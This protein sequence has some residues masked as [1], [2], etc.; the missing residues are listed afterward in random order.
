MF[1]PV[2]VSSAA[3]YTCTYCPLQ[4][5]FHYRPFIGTYNNRTIRTIVI[6][7][8]R[9]TH[10]DLGPGGGGE[11]T[12]GTLEGAGIHVRPLVVLHI[13]ASVERLHAY[14]AG[15][16]LGAETGRTHCRGRSWSF[17]AQLRYTTN[18]NKQHRQRNTQCR[19]IFTCQQSLSYL[20]LLQNSIRQCWSKI[21]LVTFQALWPRYFYSLR[22]TALIITAKTDV[23]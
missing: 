7:T 6:V 12:V 23:L 5:T 1:N 17:T 3:K 18:A 4:E 15:E 8:H 20:H 10:L 22:R 19:Q 11:V 16:P 2:Q 14:A 21:V 9:E 13:R